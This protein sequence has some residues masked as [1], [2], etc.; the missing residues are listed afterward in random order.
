MAINPNDAV[1]WQALAIATLTRAKAV[2]GSD[3]DNSRDLAR[4]TVSAA[5]NAFLRSE[6]TDARA[7]ALRALANGMEYSG[8]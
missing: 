8:R 4:S 5:L 2:A 3:N 6:N 7:Y 1:V